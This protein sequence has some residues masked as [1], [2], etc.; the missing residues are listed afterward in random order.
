MNGIQYEEEKSGCRHS[1][2]KLR[3]GSNTSGAPP[4]SVL[5]QNQCWI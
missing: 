1:L 4:F 3:S 2:K 5:P